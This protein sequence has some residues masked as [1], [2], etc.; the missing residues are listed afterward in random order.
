[1]ILLRRCRPACQ[2]SNFK[3]E[4]WNKNQKLQTLKL[5]LTYNES[6]FIEVCEKKTGSPY[7]PRYL[8]TKLSWISQ[9]QINEIAVRSVTFRN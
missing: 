3:Q 5:P 9:K 7:Q 8:K 4:I 2:V 1:M 6:S